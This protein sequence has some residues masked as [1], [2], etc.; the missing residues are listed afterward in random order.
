M[1]IEVWEAKMKQGKTTEA[2]AL[3]T[4]WGE[5]LPASHPR[6]LRPETGDLSKIFLMQEFDSMAEREEAY[7]V[8]ADDRSAMQSR[9]DECMTDLHNYYY[10]TSDSF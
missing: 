4:A 3:M 5:M 1:V 2:V 7:N 8:P 9:F 6:V 10:K